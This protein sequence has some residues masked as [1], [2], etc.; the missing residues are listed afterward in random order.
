[1]KC[2]K[3]GAIMDRW[4]DEDEAIFCCFFCSTVVKWTRADDEYEECG[5]EWIEEDEE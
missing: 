3:C 2:P 1:M 5:D 4:D